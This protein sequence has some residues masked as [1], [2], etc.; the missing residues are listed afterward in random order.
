MC[1]S[2]P[3]ST[4]SS[5]A[6]EQDRHRRGAA[7]GD[8]GDR[9]PG[10]AGAAGGRLPDPALED[11]RA[12]PSGAYDGEPRDVRA[13]R[14]QLVMLNPRPDCGQVERVEL[15]LA[16]DGDRALRV[17]DL[18]M[19]K[20]PRLRAGCE[21]AAPVWRA[22]REIGALKPRA[23]D[24]DRARPRRGDR[25][26]DLPCGGLDR[27]RVGVG[28]AAPAQVQDRFTGAVARQL[29]LR[30]VRVEDPQPRREPGL[31][32]GRQQQDAVR[33]HAGVRR[34]RSRESAPASARTEAPRSSTIR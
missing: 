6:V 7:P 1:R 24:V 2:S 26:A 3:T 9:G 27:E 8:V 25:G 28:P 13:V 32:S 33:E 34:R 16:G 17:A 29:G 20:G 18:D 14:K 4:S 30:A 10:R 11:P 22:G 31:V 12:D 21:L 23:A 15:R 5:P 19:L